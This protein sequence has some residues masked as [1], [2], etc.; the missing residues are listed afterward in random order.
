MKWGLVEEREFLRFDLKVNVVY[1]GL[2]FED[3]LIFYPAT[4]YLF[5]CSNTSR[6]KFLCIDYFVKFVEMYVQKGSFPL[7][8]IILKFMGFY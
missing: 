7:D 8:F 2:L 3:E 1:G 6:L 5:D 4:P